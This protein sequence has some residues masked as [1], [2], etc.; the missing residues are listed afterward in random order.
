MKVGDSVRLL[1][2]P[3]DHLPNL[4]IGRIYKVEGFSAS[5][6]KLVRISYNGILLPYRLLK[7]RFEVVSTCEVLTPSEMD[8][9]NKLNGPK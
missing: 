6:F 7:S 3:G 2:T 8:R 1:S 5:P 9:I 4:I